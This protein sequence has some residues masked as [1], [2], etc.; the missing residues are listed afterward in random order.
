MKVFSLNKRNDLIECLIMLKESV[1]EAQ[2]DRAN[3]EHELK[4]SIEIEYLSKTA[5]DVMENKLKLL[6]LVTFCNTGKYPA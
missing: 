4:L 2:Q 6:D 3:F 5:I 1:V